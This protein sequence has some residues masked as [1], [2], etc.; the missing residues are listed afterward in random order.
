MPTVRKSGRAKHIC[1]RAGRDGRRYQNTSRSRFVLAALLA[2]WAYFSE[3]AAEL[4]GG[5]ALEA[6]MKA[7]V[8]LT[9]ASGPA[10]KVAD[11]TRASSTQWCRHFQQ[12]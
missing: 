12:A 7:T 3:T 8:G 10:A 1:D 6:K 9:R 11:T 4:P 2:A 5:L